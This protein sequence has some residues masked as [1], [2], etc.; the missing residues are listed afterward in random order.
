[1]RTLRFGLLLVLSGSA[2]SQTAA[3]PAFDVASIRPSPAKFGSY[4]RY[5]PGG[6]LSAMSWIRQV[7][8]VAYGLHDYQVLGGPGWLN[9]DRYNIEAKAANPDASKDDINVMMQTLLSDRFKLKFH[10]ETKD[11]DVYDLVVDKNGSKMKPLKDG[12]DFHCTRDNTEICG[13]TNPAQVASFLRSVTGKPVFD[14]TGITGRYNILLTFDVYEPKGATPP[15]GY[16]KPL[17]EDALGDQLGLQ[18][19][20]RKDTLPVLVIDSIE[21]PS[22]N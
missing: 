21:R 11:F 17:L 6:S 9:T 22:E 7:V 1:M 18:L 8:Q 20:P 15:E 16:N 5:Q 19:V 14:K 3:A 12:E 4:I 10:R 13:L 2:L